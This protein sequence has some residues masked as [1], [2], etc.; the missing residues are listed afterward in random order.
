MLKVL[1]DATGAPQNVVLSQSSGF[2]RLDN[3]AI[4]REQRHSWRYLGNTLG[5]FLLG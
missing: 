1:I 4:A 2:S 3:A 5:L